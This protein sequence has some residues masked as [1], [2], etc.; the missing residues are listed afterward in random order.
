MDM[1]K[2]ELAPIVP[3]AWEEIDT[4]AKRVLELNL[5]ARKLVDFDGPHGWDLAAVNKGRL[6]ILESE[7]R[8]V[9]RGVREVLPLAELRVPVR[10][11]IMELDRV[12]RGAKDP[13]L[14]PLVEAAEAI[15]LV[16]DEAVFV[17]DQEL[18]IVGIEQATPHQPLKLG[19]D[20]ADYP[21]T[22]VE[23]VQT[24]RDAGINGPYGLAV[25]NQTD[26]EIARAAEDGYPVSRKIS[27]IIEGPVVRSPA[28][29]GAVLL[30]VRGGDF[31]LTSGADFA[32]GYAHHDADRVELY[33]AESF[34][35]R[36]LDPGAAVLLQHSA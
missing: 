12:G 24:L 26:A 15:A 31:E 14:D 35:F 16:E 17:G 27:R 23:A 33:L 18:G 19:A 6:R 7:R 20:P 36:V 25:G 5:G 29:K 30:S 9:F 10:L 11:D 4:E 8:G 28:L 21:Q 34:T 22:V 1:L 2:R 13:E 32:V 3:A